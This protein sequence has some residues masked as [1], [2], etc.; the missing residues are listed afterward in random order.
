ME[1]D[2]SLSSFFF[3]SFYDVSQSLPLKLI[4]ALLYPTGWGEHD[5]ENFL[6]SHLPSSSVLRSDLQ[7]A[8][9]L[10]YR[11]LERLSL[12]PFLTKA[13]TPG[14]LTVDDM[15]A[16]LSILLQRPSWLAPP[17]HFATADAAQVQD[18]ARKFRALLFRSM[19]LP[20]SHV[21]KKEDDHQQGKKK[22]THLLQDDD[23]EDVRQVHLMLTQSRRYRSA[24]LPTL[25]L[26]GPPIIALQDLP[27]SNSADLSGSIPRDEFEAL[28]RICAHLASG[29]QES[30]QKAETNTTTDPEMELGWPQFDAEIGSQSSF[31]RGMTLL[32]EPFVLP[33][34]KSDT[35]EVTS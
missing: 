21:A 10:L 26:P 24:R 2:A 34:E 1:G 3:W 33:V 8:R 16:A 20:H 15:L 7:T 9:W 4:W 28:V 35:V 11:C 25:M 12:Y 6:A 13:E 14:L 32:F 31:I 17:S 19:R 27:S 29:G 18:Q 23:N 30:K 5:I 22:E